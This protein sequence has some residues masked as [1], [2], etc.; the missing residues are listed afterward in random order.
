M[1]KIVVK[2]EEMNQAEGDGREE[3]EEEKDDRIGRDDEDIIRRELVT[4]SCVGVGF[5]NFTKGIM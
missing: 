2:E 1:Y 5:S 4:L 3:E